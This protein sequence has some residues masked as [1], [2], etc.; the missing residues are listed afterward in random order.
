MARLE[1]A[2]EF[3]AIA[4]K[5][6]A[7]ERKHERVLRVLRDAFDDGD[8]VRV[9]L[10]AEKLERVLLEIDRAFVSNPVGRGRDA[11]GPRVIVRASERA[12]TGAAD[13]IETLLDD[14]LIA[15]GLLDDIFRSAPSA[16]KIAIK[17]TFMMAY[18][19]ADPSPHVDLSLAVSLAR[20]LRDRGAS[21][22]AYLEATNHYDLFFGRR[23]VEEVA[24]Y[25]G[26]QSP[27]FRVVDVGG[28][29]VNHAFP[30]GFG[31][32]SV[33]HTWRDADVRVVLG[34]MRTNPAWLV[35]LSLNTL[36]SLG[37]RIDEMLFHD[38]NVD[39][40]AGLMMLIDAFPPDL[41]LLDATHH[42]PHGVTGILGGS[43]RRDPRVRDLVRRGVIV[44]FW[45][46]GSAEA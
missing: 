32:S 1:S 8:V 46:S 33:S 26:F 9:D 18:D 38:R 7:D 27:L 43:D 34:K 14:T 16:P 13:A 23:S 35:H 6:A 31:Q 22:V 17:T 30:R 24:R 45:R 40:S 29:Q 42:V 3:S 25:I 12:R 41:A 15:T 4:R 28:E 44:G 5:I 10:D 37:R 2:T 39:L 21:D 19:R 20:L 36:E 11:G